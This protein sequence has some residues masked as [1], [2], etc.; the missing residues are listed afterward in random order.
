MTTPGGGGSVRVGAVDCGTNSIRLLVAEGV[1]GEPGLTDVVREMRIIRLGEGV[2][3]TGRL[4]E[5]AISRCRTAL[6]DYV[7][8]MAELGVQS[9]RMVAT[10]ATRDAANKDEFFGMTAEVLGAHFPGAV[11]EVIS[12][13]TEAELTFAGGVSDLSPG[14]GP[15]VVTDLGG[16][17]TEIVVGELVRGE[18]RLLGARS[19]DIGCVRITE[20]VL[21]SDPP[22][23]DEI[24]E[25]RGVVSAALAEAGEVPVGRAARWVGVAGTFTTLSALAQG[26]GE[27]DPER[28]HGSVITLDRMREVCGRLVASSVTERRALG[29][30]HPGR[31]DVIGGGALVVQALCDVMAERAGLSELTVSEKDILDGI[32]MSV[33]TRLAC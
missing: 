17:S 20:R 8:T 21:H 2:D 24:A 19:L 1:P 9:V 3:A 13:Q 31:A 6:T 10:S 30:M 4:S 23:A 5:G 18:V 25:A 11:A 7:A 15:F 22:N 28:I 12:G 29:A 27:Y 26:L 32:A 33:L 14:D 16:G